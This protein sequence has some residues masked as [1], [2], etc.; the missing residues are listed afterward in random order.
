M[1][2][3]FEGKVVSSKMQ[4]TAVVEVTRRK[5]HPLYKKLLKRSTRFKVET[6]GYS[7]NIGDKVKIVETR[8]ISKGK[9]FKI[10][11]VLPA[12]RQGIKQ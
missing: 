5:P 6:G 12:G 2:K 8:P 9:Y 10:M 1:Q 4:N 11:E 7:V 3:T